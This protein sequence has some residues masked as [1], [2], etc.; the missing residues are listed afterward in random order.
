[1]AEVKSMVK[2]IAKGK[3]QTF[4][5]NGQTGRQYYNILWKIGMN[6]NTGRSKEEVDI[7]TRMQFGRTRFNSSLLIIQKHADGNC[8]RT[9]STD[10]R[11]PENSQDHRQTLITQLQ[12]KQVMFNWENI[13]Q[14]NSGD[15]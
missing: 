6:R 14:M 12:G 4:W 1:M 8:K 15:E 5:D 13:L 11:L 9:C 7:F 3:W 2:N 10:C